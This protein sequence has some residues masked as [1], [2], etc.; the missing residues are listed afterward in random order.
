MDEINDYVFNHLPV[1]D[2]TN[3]LKVPNDK[4]NLQ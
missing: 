3:I 4:N 2:V 1:Q